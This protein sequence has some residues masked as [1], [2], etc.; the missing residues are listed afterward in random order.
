MTSNAERIGGALII[1]LM[2]AAPAFFVGWKLGIGLGEAKERNRHNTA[3]EV[4][5]KELLELIRASN[6]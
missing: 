5:H 4:R 3:D 1:A 2:G 6:N